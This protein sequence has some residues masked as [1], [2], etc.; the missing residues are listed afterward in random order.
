MCLSKA[1]LVKNGE[2]QLV[3]EE[4]SSVRLDDNRIILSTLFG[5]QK[6]V[7]AGIKEID[8]MTHHILLEEVI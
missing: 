5:E 3:L 8:F 4:V 7:K 2:R 1:Y 6:E